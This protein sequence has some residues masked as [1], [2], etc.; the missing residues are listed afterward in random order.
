MPDGLAV[1]AE[2]GVWVAA[3]GGGCATR[4]SPDGSLDRHVDVPA[5]SVTSLAF[6]GSDGRDLY[7]VSADNTDDASLGGSIFRTRVE[8]PGLAAPLARV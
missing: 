4:F 8:V 1:D 2:G 3:Y 6:G 5:Q 7:V